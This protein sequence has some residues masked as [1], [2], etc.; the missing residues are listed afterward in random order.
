MRIAA[1]LLLAL[2]FAAPAAAA[3]P[4]FGIFDLRDLAR[5]SHN[6]YGDVKVAKSPAALHGFVVR[7]GAG[8]RFGSGWLSFAKAPSLD[9]ADVAAATAVAG[10]FGWS[11]DLTLTRAGKARWS[12]FGKAA[13]VRE[14]RNG[15]PDVLAVVVDGSILAL[16]YTSDTRYK[17]GTLRLTGFERAG[18]LRAAKTLG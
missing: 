1:L 7:C 4:R 17:R 16:P 18:A 14:R 5:D 2:A 10:R 9:A 13:T 8:C 15:V 3:A 11:V 12:A 6:V